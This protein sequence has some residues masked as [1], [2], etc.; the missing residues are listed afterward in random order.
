MVYRVLRYRVIVYV[1]SDA[2]MNVASSMFNFEQFSNS[3]S[4]FFFFGYYE[5]IYWNCFYANYIVTNYCIV[6]RVVYN[7]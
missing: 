5:Y 7:I 1:Q 2:R 3:S 4:L 6:N